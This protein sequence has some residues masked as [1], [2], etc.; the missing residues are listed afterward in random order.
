M[1]IFA[2]DW[3]CSVE[4]VGVDQDGCFGWDVIAVDDLGVVS[5][6]RERID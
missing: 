6:F 1:A 3:C 2:P 5:D 4:G